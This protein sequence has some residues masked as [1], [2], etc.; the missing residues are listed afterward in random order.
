MVKATSVRIAIRIKG[1][2]TV[3]CSFAN[4]TVDVS[5]GTAVKRDV[6]DPGQSTVMCIAE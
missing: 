5:C 4:D 1:G 2:P 6:I 3:V